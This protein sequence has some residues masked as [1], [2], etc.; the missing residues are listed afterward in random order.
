MPFVNTYLV[1]K[2][3]SQV[4]QINVCSVRVHVSMNAVLLCQSI[5]QNAAY[6][7]FFF[8]ELHRNNFQSY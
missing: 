8:K 6:F 4:I 1:H 3:I 7:F 2:K 5:H